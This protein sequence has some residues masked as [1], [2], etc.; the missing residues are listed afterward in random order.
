MCGHLHV[1]CGRRVS[2][3]G[4]FFRSPAYLCPVLHVSK[5]FLNGFGQTA[6][7]HLSLSVK[8]KACEDNED[9]MVSAGFL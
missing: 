6:S 2:G 9:A 1:V 4:D 7:L 3:L 5:D 8:P